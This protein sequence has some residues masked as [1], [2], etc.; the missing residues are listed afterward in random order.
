[1][2]TFGYMVIMIFIK[3]NIDYTG[4]T[5]EAPAILA[6]FL[7]FVLKRGSTDGMNLYGKDG[8]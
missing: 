4:R 3:W 5:D 8:V 1:M 2:S 7:N 6:T